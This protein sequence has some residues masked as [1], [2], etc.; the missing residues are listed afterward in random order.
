MTKK[1]LE[2]EAWFYI[3]E[4]END[5]YTLDVVCGRVGLYNKIVTLT[6]EQVEQYHRLGKDYITQLAQGIFDKG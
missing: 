3:L 6:S 2:E 4:C 1:R 5:I